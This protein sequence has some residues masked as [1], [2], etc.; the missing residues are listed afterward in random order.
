MNDDIMTGDRHGQRC[1]H[2]AHSKD[3]EKTQDICHN[4]ELALKERKF[5]GPC[6]EI[7]KKGKVVEELGRGLPVDGKDIGEEFC[8][9]AHTVGLERDN[10]SFRDT[11]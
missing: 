8:Q 3:L 2:L 7:S 4:H 9:A 6:E 5:G 10:S 11:N 1:V